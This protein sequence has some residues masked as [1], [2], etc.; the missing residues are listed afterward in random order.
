MIA[1]ALLVLALAAVASEEAVESA[2]DA[3]SATEIHALLA[4]LVE[5]GKA[6]GA[7][8]LIGRGNTELL[9]DHAGTITPE[10]PVATASATKWL[11]DARKHGG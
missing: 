7:A 4:S 11:A 2:I 1:L 8:L 5:S 3:R 6:E 10:T 9:R